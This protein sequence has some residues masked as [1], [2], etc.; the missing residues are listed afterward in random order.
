VI[1]VRVRRL[2]CAACDRLQC[3]LRDSENPAGQCPE[4]RWQRWHG[5]LAPEQLRELTTGISGM[6]ATVGPRLWGELHRAPWEVSPSAWPAWLAMFA[7]RIPCGE[8]RG[9]FEALIRQQ[10][11]DFATASRF[12]A[13]T[14]AIHNAVNSRLNRPSMAIETAFKLWAPDGATFIAPVG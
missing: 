1:W 14:V 13:W 12:F 8:C 5:S 6:M 10:P 11:P 4:G 2:K 9:H 3:P 7:A